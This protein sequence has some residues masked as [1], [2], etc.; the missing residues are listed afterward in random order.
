M[1]DNNFFQNKQRAIEQLRE[2]NRRA[3]IT[4][5]A[6]KSK[7]DNDKPAT[8][9]VDNDM[10]LIIGLIMILA[11]ENCDKL[12]ILALLYLLN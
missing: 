10:L 6:T 11:N 1:A 9:T 5:N 2:M 7:S 4:D 12:L 8:F 3:K